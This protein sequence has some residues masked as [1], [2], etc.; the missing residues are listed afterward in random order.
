MLAPSLVKDSKQWMQLTM[1]V[2]AK[3][4][5]NFKG[6]ILRGRLTYTKIKKKLKT[7]GSPKTVVSITCRGLLFFGATGRASDEG[8]EGTKGSIS[9]GE[10]LSGLVIGTGSSQ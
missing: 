6:G 10:T 4:K 8:T 2:L 5:I 7:H 1:K 3:L 9:H